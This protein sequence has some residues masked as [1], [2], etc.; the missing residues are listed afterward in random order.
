MSRRDEPSQKSAFNI[1]LVN[2]Q[3]FVLGVE[4]DR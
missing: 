2:I 3:V 1:R 4:P